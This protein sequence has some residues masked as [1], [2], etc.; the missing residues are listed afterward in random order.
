LS[1][2]FRQLPPNRNES[3]TPY[4]V[5][6]IYYE[7]EEHPAGIIKLE[8]LPPDN[9]EFR[10]P[11]LIENAILCIA[12]PRRSHFIWVGYICINRDDDIETSQQMRFL[13][14]IHMN[15]AEVIVW[16][17]DICEP[18]FMDLYQVKIL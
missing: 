2:S 5:L 17:G 11:Q 1:F 10:I 7:D 15:T 14:A 16:A 4:I 6:A 13:K 3:D 12:K 9:S 18:S 8:S